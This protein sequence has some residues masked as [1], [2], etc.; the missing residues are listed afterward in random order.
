M[1]PQKVLVLPPVRASS[2]ANPKSVSTTFP[3]DVRQDKLLITSAVQQNIFRL[4]ISVDNIQRVKVLNSQHYL[5]S[6]K[7][8]P[9]FRE[10]SCTVRQMI[11]KNYLVL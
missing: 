10:H 8:D 2:L 1:V 5:S 11:N 4:Q 7:L 9:S 3:T 6:V